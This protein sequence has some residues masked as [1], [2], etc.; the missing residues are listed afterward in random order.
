[1][2]FWRYAEGHYGM[3]SKELRQYRYSLKPLKDLYGTSPAARFTPKCLKAVRQRMADLGWRRSVI[4]RRLVRIKTVWS[5][6]VSEELVPPS[7]AHALREVKGFRKGEKGVLESEPVAPAYGED[8]AKVL[9]FCTR[10]V[11]A[12]LQLQWLTGMRSGEVRIMRTVDID[13]SNPQC[14]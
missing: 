7:A 6:A 3:D 14:W 8:V 13:Q 12:M 10:P 11:A 1:L 5:W 4:N 2:A 9:P